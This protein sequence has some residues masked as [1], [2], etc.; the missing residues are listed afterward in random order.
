MVFFISFV[1]NEIILNIFFSAKANFIVDSYK[2]IRIER[3]L[4]I[5]ISKF[6]FQNKHQ[7]IL[8]FIIEL[9]LFQFVIQFS[10]S[11]SFLKMNR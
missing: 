10:V 4:I 3:I 1:F 11:D 2:I 6:N 5:F 7:D 8:T 9:F